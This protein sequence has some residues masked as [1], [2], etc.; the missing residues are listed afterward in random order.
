MALNG[1]SMT[2][3]LLR[4]LYQK[5]ILTEIDVHFARFI[6][7]LAR[8]DDPAVGLGAALVSRITGDGHICLDLAAHAQR[9][10]LE[11]K[12]D[13]NA[14][15][16]PPLGEWE[17]ALIGSGAVGRPGE[18]C[19]LI[20][21]DAN[22]LYLFRYWAYEQ[23]L[24]DAVK[25]R[26][27]QALPA[28]S[29][30]LDLLKDGLKRLFPEQDDKTIDWQKIAALTAVLKPFCVISGGPG[31]GKTFTAAK[32]LALLMEQSKGRNSKIL[33]AA[34]T[35]KAAARLG[36]SLK[37]V[38]QKLD[39][40]AAVKDAIPV[41]ARTIHR[42]L[43][44]LPGTPHFRYNRDNPLPADVV[45]VDEASMVD[46]ALMAKLIQ[47]IPVSARLIL[48]GDKDQ[49]ASVEA[50]AVLGD[51]CGRGH[52]RGFS[53]SFHTE[54]EALTG[55][56]LRE[57]AP[58]SDQPGA[59]KDCIVQLRRNY[60]FAKDS[61][62]A[63]LGLA[64]NRGDGRH[65]F[66][67]LAN[68]AD[69][70]VRLRPAA[71]GG[72]L[73]RNLKKAV[74]QGYRDY[75][76]APTPQEALE[77]FSQFKLLCAVNKGPFGVGALN[78]L[79]E[80][81]LARED[82]IHPGQPF[83]DQW[84]AGRPVLITRNDYR[85]DLFNGDIG[86]TMTGAGSD[87]DRLYVFFPETKG[88]RQIPVYRLSD[89]QTVFALTVHKSQG[90]EFEDVHLILP[91]TDVPV[92]TRELVYTAVTRAKRSVTIWGTEKILQAAI[93][94]KI[95]RSSGLRDGLWGRTNQN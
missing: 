78:H 95:Q 81:I 85:L 66:E 65:A 21:D 52:S 12:G 26:A 33:L 58:H 44:P 13:R 55:E 62:I 17:S 89:H 10:L 57:L 28:D 39:C 7:G 68:S 67:L 75:L 86:L 29:L 18:N 24:A 87:G 64:L 60:R 22:R 94:R 90:S 91:D 71:S 35:G 92:L 6:S 49:L 1:N 59:L 80:Q 54:I 73:Q 8:A 72:D 3:K 32:I 16:C 56:N 4:Q 88:A 79:A 36:E 43:Q 63:E 23:I 38:G 9:V 34:P 2:Q 70:T 46:L 14:I 74:I 19:P 48:M 25:E 76:A 40:S 82:L 51:L 53:A 69:P 5:G 77:K 37:V 30:D 20:L 41:E 31:T 42:L 15:I 47:A 83:D 45:M 50:G 61:A 93:D 11:G 84:Y 27:S